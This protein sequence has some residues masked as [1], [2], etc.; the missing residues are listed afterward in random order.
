[1]NWTHFALATLAA[2]IAS[3]FTD[4]FFTG[5]LFHDQ[6]RAYPEVWRKR[7]SEGSTIAWATLLGFVTAAS[8]MTACVIFEIHGY[9]RAL[10]F[11]AICW[12]M[13]PL[14]FTIMNALYIKLHPLVA[15][16]HALGWLARLIVAA[17]A[18]GWLLN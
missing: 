7:T 8:F 9:S 11:A 5:I 6:Y 2:G 3:S 18:G 10:V 17:I 13:A 1:M 12:I 15:V 4:W 16:A 14:P